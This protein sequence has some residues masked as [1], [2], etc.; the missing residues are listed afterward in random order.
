[1]VEAKALAHQAH[2]SDWVDTAARIGLLAFGLVHVVVGWLALQLALGDRAGKASGEGAIRELAEKPFGLVVVCVVG[3]GLVLLALWRAL[4]A[5]VGHRDDEGLMRTRHRL[6]DAARTVVYG[7][8][9]WSAFAVVAG[10]GSS[11]DGTR[12]A[13]ARLM[14]QPGGQ[15]LVAAVGAVIV[16]IGV[17]LVHRAWTDRFTEEMDQR[18]LR[19]TSGTVYVWLGRTGSAAKG[20]AYGIVG[21]LFGWAAATHEPK[22]SGGLDQALAE[23]L[24]KPLG[25]Y[26]LVVIALGFVAFGLFCFVQAWHFDR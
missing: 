14:G 21:I 15:L 22:K 13:T 25:P 8:L 4:E 5:L 1:M 23:L 10:S 18:G 19:G 16:G 3:A 26:L 9:A 7:Y 6:T 24:D 12:S 2:G 11:G 20:V 17:T